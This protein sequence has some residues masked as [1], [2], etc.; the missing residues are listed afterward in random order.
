[1]FERLKLPKRRAAPPATQRPTSAKVPAVSGRMRWLRN[2]VIGLAVFLVLVAVIGFFVVPPIA[3]HYL[4]KGL[5]EQLGRQ[6]S[7]A[8]IDVNP[9]AMTVLIKDF[10]VM[11]PSGAPVFIALDALLVNA[12][13]RSI[14]R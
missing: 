13:Y 3:K 1:M 9:F 5:S 12:E 7:I 14:L 2:I 8:D 10:K 11:E 6:V 4:V